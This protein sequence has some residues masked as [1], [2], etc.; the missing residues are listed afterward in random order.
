MR[1]TTLAAALAC[2]LP[3]ALGDGGLPHACG[4]FLC[5]C[6]YD[7]E[8]AAPHRRYSGF[9]HDI[10]DNACTCMKASGGHDT[11]PIDTCKGGCLR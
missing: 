3:L 8:S 6:C 7:R 1:F 5:H 2:I 11:Y 9:Y 4:A 10:I